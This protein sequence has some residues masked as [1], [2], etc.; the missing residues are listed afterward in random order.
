MQNRRRCLFQSKSTK[1]VVCV[2]VR[3]YLFYNPTRT[4]NRNEDEIERL[5]L[6]DTSRI[7]K[8]R[9]IVLWI[10]F[11]GVNTLEVNEN[12]LIDLHSRQYMVFV[13]E[14]VFV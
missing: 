6:S 7:K 3:E 9:S 14:L 11:L 10:N 12:R 13:I 5:I 1:I 2:C 8:E 4:T